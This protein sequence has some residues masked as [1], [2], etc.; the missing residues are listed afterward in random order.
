MSGLIQFI[1]L[2]LLFTFKI[3]SCGLL[4]VKVN[5]ILSCFLIYVLLK[6]KYSKHIDPHDPSLGPKPFRKT[7]CYLIKQSP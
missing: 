2:S 5:K 7:V 6:I 4:D 3:V 1:Y